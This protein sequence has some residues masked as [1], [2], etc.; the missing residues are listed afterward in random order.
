MDDYLSQRS[1]AVEAEQRVVD[2]EAALQ[3]ISGGGPDPIELRQRIAALEAENR[4]LRERLARARTE[5]ERIMTR[6][7][8][9]EGQR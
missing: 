3:A 6:L 1:R 8:F 5:A 2:L 4:S 7:H 9:L